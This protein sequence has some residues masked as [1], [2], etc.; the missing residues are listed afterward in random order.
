MTS[1]PP[2]DR[3]LLTDSLWEEITRSC[4]SDGLETGGKALG[5]FYTDGTAVACLHIGGVRGILGHVTRLAV[6]PVSPTPRARRR[7]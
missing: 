1:S 5:R 2:I 6:P 3:L 7:L 4:P